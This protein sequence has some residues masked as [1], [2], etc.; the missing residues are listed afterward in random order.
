M[1]VQ[2]RT[3]GGGHIEDGVTYR[4]NLPITRQLNMK[5]IDPRDNKTLFV[6]TFAVGEKDGKLFLLAS[7]RAK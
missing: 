1:R 2:V 3:G 6:L 4:M 5:A 7:A